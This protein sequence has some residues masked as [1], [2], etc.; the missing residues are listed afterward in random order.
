LNFF[1]CLK[2]KERGQSFLN[3]VDKESL[4]LVRSHTNGHLEKQNRRKIVIIAKH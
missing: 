2:V 4:L 1:N 3:L